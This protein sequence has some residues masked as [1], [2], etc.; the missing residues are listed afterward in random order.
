MCLFVVVHLCVFFS[1]IVFLLFS[2]VSFVNKLLY[3]LC[4]DHQIYANILYVRVHAYCGMMIIYIYAHVVAQFIKEWYN[5]KWLFLLIFYRRFLTTTL[6]PFHLS[7]PFTSP[8]FNDI[9]HFFNYINIIYL[10]II[11]NVSNV[12][13]HIYLNNQ[14][15]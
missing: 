15:A 12:R 10:N 4:Y 14:L 2:F 11:S 13:I 1:F 8:K 6:N 7:V 3:S 9:F 5:F